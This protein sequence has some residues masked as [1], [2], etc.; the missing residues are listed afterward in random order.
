MLVR[1]AKYW[2]GIRL[3]GFCI[4]ALSISSRQIAV[5]I[6]YDAYFFGGYFADDTDSKSRAREW[7]T[8]YEFF[9]NSKLKA[10]FSYFIF[11][12]VTQR[13]DDFFEINVV[14][15]SS[16]V[17]MGFDDCGFSAKAALYNVRINGSLYKEVYS[18]DFLCFFLEDTDKFFADDFTFRLRLCNAGKLACNIAAV[19]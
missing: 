9:R 3:R 8:E 10:G 7:L 2:F 1:A 11:E 12:E 15:K 4:P 6:L 14:R 18:A 16:Y 5:G 17:V 13:L 19:R